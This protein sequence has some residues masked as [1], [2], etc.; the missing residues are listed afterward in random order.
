MDRQVPPGWDHA[1]SA[2]CAQ[3][4]EHALIRWITGRLAAPASADLLVDV[5]DDAAVVRP[6]RNHVDVLTT[7]VMVD[8]V[9]FSRAFSDARDVGHRALHVN[10]SDVAAMGAEPRWALLSLGLPGDLEA[11]WVADLVDGLVEA[12]E[13]MRVRLIGGNISRSPALFVDVT[14]SGT[15][16]PRHV[17]RRSGARVGDELYVSG[18]VGAAAAGLAWLQLAGGGAPL[19]LLA[20]HT[21]PDAP[22]TGSPDGAGSQEGVVPAELELAVTRYRRPEARVALGVQVGRNKAA[23]ACMDTSDGLA[24]A[25]RQLAAASGVG[26]RIE[27]AALP[28]SPAIAPVAAATGADPEVLAW[29]G[30]EDYELV[31]AV[32]RRSRR[33]FMHAT[34]RKG[35]PPVTRIGVCTRDADVCIVEADGRVRPV[36]GGFEHF[37]GRD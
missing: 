5:G 11:R 2:T 32:P 15:A 20:G 36:P 16:K 3:V 37:G 9:H 17:L 26:M 27:A 33:R 22:T 19:R 21:S 23:S 6:R 24:D 13:A 14:V 10:L 30:G 18:E 12:A 8:G 1:P 28:C 31:F 25:L 35:L 4:G 34:T 7:D 29:S